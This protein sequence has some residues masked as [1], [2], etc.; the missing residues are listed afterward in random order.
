[1]NLMNLT[2]AGKGVIRTMYCKQ[3]GYG[4]FLPVDLAVNGIITST[5]NF[6]ANK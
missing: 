2:G 6:I 1:M 3:D 4:D 5:W